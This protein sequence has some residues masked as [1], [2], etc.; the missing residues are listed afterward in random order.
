ME[1]TGHRSIDG[2]R[3]YKRTCPEQ[4]EKLLM[5][6]R[7]C[8]P[9]KWKVDD[10]ENTQIARI[11]QL[12][13]IW[14]EI[15]YISRVMQMPMLLVQPSSKQ[16]TLNFSNCHS[17]TINYQDQ[18]WAFYFF[19]FSK[20]GLLFSIITITLNFLICATSVY[21]VKL[22]WYIHFVAYRIT[23]NLTDTRKIIILAN[24][25]KN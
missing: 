18:S 6:F 23:S 21:I 10:S 20:I 5:C 7:N 15:T 13:Q 24:V 1:R 8:P 9:K 22:D 11:W 14:K 4:H 16:P 3:V 17:I 2:V 25:R 19:H 12:Y